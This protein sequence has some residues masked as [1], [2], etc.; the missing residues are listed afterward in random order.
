MNLSSSLF[1]S[2]PT[3]EKMETPL[4][5]TSGRVSKGSS[6]YPVPSMLTPHTR[7]GK[8]IGRDHLSKDEVYVPSPPVIMKSNTG[9]KRIGGE[10]TSTPSVDDVIGANVLISMK[11]SGDKVVQLSTLPS[12]VT[13]ETKD[14]STPI[15]PSQSADGEQS[16]ETIMLPTPAI[17]SSSRVISVVTPAVKKKASSG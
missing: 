15:R 5:T 3:I 16:P 13:Q 9:S 8:K 10:R 4:T 17:I 7:L 11:V 6:K 12:T 14:S 1:Y 2:T